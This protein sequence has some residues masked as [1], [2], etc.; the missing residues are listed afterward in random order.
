MA[1]KPCPDNCK[2]DWLKFFDQLDEAVAHMI[3]NAGVDTPAEDY[4]PT[5]VTLIKFMEFAKINRENQGYVSPEDAAKNYHDHTEPYD[6]N[7]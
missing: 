2:F 5:K 3:D 4:H 1:I 6:H 7:R